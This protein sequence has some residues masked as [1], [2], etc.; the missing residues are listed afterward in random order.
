MEVWGDCG[1]ASRRAPGEGEGGKG[2]LPPREARYLRYLGRYQEPH[3]VGRFRVASQ[4]GGPR[5][6]EEKRRQEKREAKR[7]E[8][9][10]REEK[11]KDMNR[12]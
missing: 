8:E 5:R 10:R 9:K 2:E 6:E 3:F 1:G 11:R 4:S 7:R 12:R